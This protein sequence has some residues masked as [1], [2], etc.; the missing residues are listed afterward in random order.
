MLYLTMLWAILLIQV[1]EWAFAS[2]TAGLTAQKNNSRT[3][4]AK[5]TVLAG[6]EPKL[7]RTVRRKEMIG[8]EKPPASCIPG[9]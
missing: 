7:S 8:A 3:L 1:P 2:T 6:G 4:T 9:Q 5:P